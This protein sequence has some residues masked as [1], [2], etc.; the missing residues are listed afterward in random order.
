MVDILNILIQTDQITRQAQNTRPTL[1]FPLL[2]QLFLDCVCECLYQVAYCILK[3][4]LAC[5]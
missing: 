1:S 4:L 5:H 2:S 3:C